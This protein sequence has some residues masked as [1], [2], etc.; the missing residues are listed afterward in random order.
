M[1]L[2][3]SM[4]SIKSSQNATH[5]MAPPA[6]PSPTGRNGINVSTNKNAGTAIKGCGRLVTMHHKDAVN[7][8]IFLGSNTM[9]TASPSG[10]LWT[11]RLAEMKTP[12]SLPLDPPKLTPMPTPSEKECNVMTKIIRSTLR[13]S[14]PARPPTV[15]S[16][17]FSKKDLVPSINNKPQTPPISV[18]TVLDISESSCGS[19]KVQP[20][21]IKE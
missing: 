3:S 14:A 13:A 21:T 6:K 11:A 2:V 9:A 17:C 16:S 7:F 19:S 18:R 5:A 1:T 10:T 15:K 4:A 20:S 8:E 12:S